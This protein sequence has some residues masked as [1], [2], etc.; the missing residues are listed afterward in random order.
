MPD[1]PLK[2][3]AASSVACRHC[4]TPFRPGEREEEFCCSGCRYVF[5]LLHERGLEDFYRFGETKS[6][7]GSQVFSER[8]FAWLPA[9]QATAT[10]GT[11]TLQ[12][13]GISCA[14]CVWLLEAVFLEQPGAIAAEVNSSSGTIRLRWDTGCDL[15][16]YARDVQRFGYLLGP[17]GTKAEP[18]LRP[19]VRKLGLCGALALNAM[20]F[21]L[22]RYLGM[23]P[24]EQFAAL[25]DAIALGIATASIA[26]GAPY[27]FRRA[28]AALRRRELHIDL[29]ISLGLAVAYTGS[30][31]AWLAGDAS[32]AYFDFVSIFTFLMLLGRWLQ[33]R[34]VET[35]RNRLLGLKLTP[36]DVRVLRNGLL[37]EAPAT[38]LV[39]GERFTIRRNQVV[40]VRSRLIDGP[41]DFAMNWI[42]GEPAPRTVSRGGIVAAGARS[43]DSGDLECIALEDWS[44]SQLASLLA[45]TDSGPWK[46]HG[47]QTL[48]RIYLA[49]VLVVAA[50]GFLV[51]GVCGGDW[52][53][54][55]Q[56]LIS[57]LVVSCPCAIGVALPLLD[58]VAAARL[59]PFG[60][61]LREASLWQRLPRVRQILF[62][63]TGTLTLEN[64]VP[65]DPSAIDSLP[66]RPI[67]LRL[68]FDSLHPIACCLREHLLAA[69]VKPA[70]D[71]GQRVVEYPG[72]GLEWNGWRLG[73]ATWATVDSDACGTVLAHDGEVVASFSFREEIRP[74]ATGQV[75]EF[76]RRGFGIALLSGDEPTRVTRMATTLGLPASS[77]FGGLTPQEKARLVR[78]RW[79][80]CSLMLGDGAND[81]LAF[82]AAL[83]RGTPASDSGLLEH[84]ADFYL[85]GR[86]LRGLGALFD[87]STAHTRAGRAVTAFAL[88]YNACA[89]GASL[90]GWM[91]PLLAAVIMPLSSLVSI[92][93]VFL[94]LKSNQ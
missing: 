14:G 46:N 73:R 15:V 20:L 33:E 7:I 62:D 12:V 84:K 1:V 81:S 45:L 37:Q 30:V 38:S 26:I 19:L 49:I 61:Y 71:D 83:C 70:P 6:P 2:T 25:F 58:D 39:T 4:A 29:P 9:L 74:D 53:G 31:V 22:P 56:V 28:V 11:L 23:N 79:S 89:V 43:L 75:Q 10:S 68:T 47:L 8:D 55:F 82:D 60:V 69:G 86:S 77:A 50:T 17:P 91:N 27:F 63:K 72:L 59:Q 18:T 44:T 41:G 5:H 66:E 78:E 52:L 54:A 85:L 13:Q 57:I 87:M 88:A 90:A 32:F 48:I 67:L 65:T 34:A 94:F 35:N 3:A 92:S 36:D 40:P 21:A 80:A 64:L 42:N 51:W 16:R 24:G 93:L 76:S